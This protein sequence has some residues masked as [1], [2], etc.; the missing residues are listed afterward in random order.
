MNV[1]GNAYEVAGRD[2]PSSSKILSSGL[3]Q[4]GPLILR[5]LLFCSLVTSAV[6]SGAYA[7]LG[8]LNLGMAWPIAAKQCVLNDNKCHS[9]IDYQNGV[10]LANRMGDPSWDVPLVS[11]EFSKTF[12]KSPHLVGVRGP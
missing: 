12:G 3:M 8:R 5:A 1:R 10:A 6:G 4:I 9:Q 7:A 2:S 11:L